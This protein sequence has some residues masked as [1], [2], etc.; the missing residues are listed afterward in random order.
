MPG[1]NDLPPD[2]EEVDFDDLPGMDRDEP[3][4]SEIPDA[5]ED[6]YANVD[7][8]IASGEQAAGG[9]EWTDAEL[10]EWY[11]SIPPGTK[12]RGEPTEEAYE[13]ILALQ[14]A[15]EA[16]GIGADGDELVDIFFGDS[17][18]NWKRLGIDL[19]TRY[20]RYLEPRIGDPPP[21]PPSPP[22]GWIDPE[23]PDLVI[24]GSDGQ[25]IPPAPP[26][27]EKSRTPLLIGGG[28]VMLLLLALLFS[29]LKSGDGSNDEAAPANTVVTESV[30]QV[31]PAAESESEDVSTEDAPLISDETVDEPECLPGEE[32]VD[33]ECRNAA[34]MMPLI[35]IRTMS[36]QL[37]GAD[38]W[39]CSSDSYLGTAE[40]AAP[41]NVDLFFGA[42]LP[43]GTVPVVG[44]FSPELSAPAAGEAYMR[45]GSVQTGF[46]SQSEEGFC[47]YGVEPVVSN[48]LECD[49]SLVMSGVMPSE[50][51]DAEDVGVSFY[52]PNPDGKDLVTSYSGSLADVPID[53]VFIQID[54]NGHVL[55]G[56]SPDAMS[57]APF[58]FGSC[59]ATV[60]LVDV[61]VVLQ[62]QG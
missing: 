20:R 51:T 57:F 9:T 26:P 44:I 53:D 24:M 11:D 58:P 47:H 16:M 10:N 27:A 6:L 12:A 50:P 17:P 34:P 29:W 35:P 46:T 1:S 5:P 31:T 43:D 22:A 56:P 3:E 59:D 61:L 39:D 60:P 28:L 45:I 54:E 14:D 48:L 38:N 13:I 8:L 4:D 42:P 30:S 40:G 52:T 19:K 41:V 25:P 33:G 21:P 23:P 36:A 37:P 7:K 49:G 55:T 32:L 15:Y 62:P 2:D 18:S